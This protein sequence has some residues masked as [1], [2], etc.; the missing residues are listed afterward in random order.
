MP[1]LNFQ[2]RFVDDIRLGRK[3]HTIRARRKHPIKAG[4]SLYL[5]CGARTARCFK[6]LP[7]PVK[8]SR[9]ESIEINAKTT[10]M[11]TLAG[12]PLTYDER[13][14]LAVADGFRNWDEMLAFWDGRLP[15]EGNIIHWR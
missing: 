12:V 14:Q 5:Y 7:E 10:G 2:S 13:E 15:F 4:D 11:V 6:I 8:C 9:V 1:L 3:L